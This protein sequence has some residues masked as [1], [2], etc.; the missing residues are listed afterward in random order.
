MYKELMDELKDTNYEVY[1]E[2]NMIGSEIESKQSTLFV[3]IL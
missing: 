2:L 1:N 3:F